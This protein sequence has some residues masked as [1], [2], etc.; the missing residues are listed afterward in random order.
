MGTPKGVHPSSE[1]DYYLAF[2]DFLAMPFPVHNNTIFIS[3]PFPKD[4]DLDLDYTTTVSDQTFD[5]SMLM[6]AF[7]G[8]ARNQTSISTLRLNLDPET[9]RCVSKNDPEPI[10][11]MSE[12]SRMESIRGQSVKWSFCL[13]LFRLHRI[14]SICSC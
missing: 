14:A 2:S 13:F 5:L 3:I 4:T 12:C 10:F 1:I 9:Q 6:R 7:D 11:Q 8:T